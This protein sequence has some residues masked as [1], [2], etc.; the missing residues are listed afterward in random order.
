MMHDFLATAAESPN[1]IRVQVEDPAAFK[2]EFERVRDALLP[3]NPSFSDLY[4]R[5]SPTKA[6]EVWILKG[7]KALIEGERK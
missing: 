2:V 7:A 6:N 1:G 5:Q 4:L 3:S